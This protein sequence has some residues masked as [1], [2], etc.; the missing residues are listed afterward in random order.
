MFYFD[1][2]IVLQARMMN[3]RLSVRRLSK[4]G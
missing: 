4:T 3:G 2:L 1:G